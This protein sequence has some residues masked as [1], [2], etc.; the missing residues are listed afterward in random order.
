MLIGGSGAGKTWS[1]RTM[2]K[3]GLKVFAIFTEPGFEVVGDIPCQ[4]LHWHYVQPATTD[5]ASMIDSAR[6]I[7]TLSFESLTKLGDI[8]KLK[9]NQYIQ[10]LETLSGFKCDR[11]GQSY[12]AVDSWAPDRVLWLD[13][14]SGLNVMAMALQVGSK[15]VKSMA[16]WGVAMDNLEWLI[17]NICVVTRCHF[18]LVA[19]A[20]RE[21]N[22]VAGGSQIMA[23]TLGRKLAPKL[24][25]YF[26]DVVLAQRQGDK[27]TWSTAAIGADLKARNLRIADGLEPDFGQIVS[28]WKSRGGR[29]G[30]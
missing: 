30:P 2:V 18:V 5:W 7:N 24:P 22:E 6:K 28:T 27:F 29:V 17:R 1:L 20:E 19:H 23:A 16:D 10:V 3:Q 15:P 13:S 9:H 14:L 26:S 12:G 25:I 11:C 8:N 21:T 4:D